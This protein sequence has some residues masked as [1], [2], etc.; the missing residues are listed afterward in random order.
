MTRRFKLVVVLVASVT[1]LTG[2]RLS[3]QLGS[4]TPAPDPDLALAQ[5]LTADLVKLR[6]S[7]GMVAVEQPDLSSGPSLYSSAHVLRAMRLT[8]MTVPR[9]N[10]HDLVT[11]VHAEAGEV[12]PLWA[13]E[14]ACEATDDGRI[15]P[16]ESDAAGVAARLHAVSSAATRDGCHESATSDQLGALGVARCLGL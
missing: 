5:A 9:P 1:L 7:T 14:W 8:G 16:P 15:R 10:D 12:D 2:V 6:D 13:W 4:S 11:A 3:G